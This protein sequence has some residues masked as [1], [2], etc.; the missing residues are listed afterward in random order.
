ML[1]RLLGVLLVFFTAL[2]LLAQDQQ[3]PVLV[4]KILNVYP[5]NPESYTQGL[6]WFDGFL[7]ESTGGTGR[8]SALR[9]LD[10]E[11]GETLEKVDLSPEFFAEG[12]EKVDDKLIQLTWKAGQAFVYDFDTFEQIDTFD[13]EG[14]GWG[15]CYDGRFVFMSD[16]TSYLSIRDPQTF[17]LIYQGAVTLNN[18]LLSPQLLNELECVGDVIYANA[19][20][21]DYILQIDKFNGN[22]IAFIDASSLLSED[23]RASLNANAVLNGIAYN[24]ETNTFFITGKDWSKLF[25]VTFEPQ[26]GQ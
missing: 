22:I 3:V 9:K 4:P 20:Q 6:L 23:E 5:H 16:S 25:E 1:K 2:P 14:E 17:D 11:T 15:I 26:D 13:Y 19:W 10:L 12:L 8:I 18:Q 24:P 7:Y 21:T